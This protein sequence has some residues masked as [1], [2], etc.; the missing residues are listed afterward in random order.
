MVPEGRRVFPLMSVKDNLLM[1]AFTRTDKVGIATTLDN[2]RVEAFEKAIEGS[3]I[4]TVGEEAVPDWD[5]AQGGVIF[6]Q[7]LTAAGGEINCIDSG[8][9][10]TVMQGPDGTRMGG[11]GCFL[12]VEAPHR[13]VWTSALNSALSGT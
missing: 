5:N 7:L 3:G 13:L 4:E 11:T 10:G 2:E 1:G 6:E 12:V 9:F 8:A